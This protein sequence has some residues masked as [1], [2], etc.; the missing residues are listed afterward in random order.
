MILRWSALSRDDR[1]AIFDYISRD[2]PRA[3]IMV[4]E[5]INEQARQL[6]A[7]PDSGRLGRI[8]RTRELLVHGT[9]YI[10]VYQRIE[11]LI[12]VLRVL[13]TAQ[14]WPTQPNSSP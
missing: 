10:I 9:S 14:A 8:P 1:D 12:R 3:A 7:F 2:S 13:H 4:D 11:H 5:R 6:L